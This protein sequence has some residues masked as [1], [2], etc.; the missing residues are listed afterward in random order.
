MLLRENPHQEVLQMLLLENYRRERGETVLQ[1]VR[2]RRGGTVATG[3]E[4]REDSIGDFDLHGF[5]H[6]S[7][8]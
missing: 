2:H 6:M 5:G 3:L 4:G 8:T 7:D 1:E